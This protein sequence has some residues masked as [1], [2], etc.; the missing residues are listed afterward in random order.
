MNWKKAKRL[1]KKGRRF[2]GAV[3]EL[4][5]GEEIY[6]AR[7]KNNSEIFRSGAKSV[8]EAI[9]E[10]KAYWALDE[11][12]LRSLRLEGVTY[13]AIFV[14]ESGDLYLASLADFLDR[15]KCRILNYEARGG[16]LQ[17]YLPLTCFRR[18]PGVTRI[19]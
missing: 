3:F 12:T 11:N 1:V 16:A 19:K 7:R 10:K 2:Y 14:M 4:P 6:I 18:Q 5:S 9:D 15:A 13:V 8:S 17:W